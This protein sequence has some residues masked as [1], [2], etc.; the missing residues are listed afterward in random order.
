M[1]WGQFQIIKSPGQK[2]SGILYLHLQSWSPR[3]C[4]NIHLG[5]PHLFPCGKNIA[6][7]PFF[8][9]FKFNVLV[10]LKWCRVSGKEAGSRKDRW[11]TTICEVILII[12]IT[13]L[14]PPIMP[15]LLQCLLWKFLSPQTKEVLDQHQLC[16]V[17]QGQQN[18]LDSPR[19]GCSSRTGATWFYLN[20]ASWVV[21]VRQVNHI[22][23][24]NKGK[25]L[26]QH[27]TCTHTWGPECG[28]S[29]PTQKV[30]HDGTGPWSQHSGGGDR[31]IPRAH[32]LDC[33]AK[34][35][36]YRFSERSQPNIHTHIHTYV[37]KQIRW[38]MIKENI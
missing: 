18:I 12:I 38:R 36:S 3:S 17:V 25:W 10:N 26:S 21:G 24:R 19:P 7:D 8:F 28:V 9:F 34:S 27:S 6:S 4:S 23:L 2:S 1:L 22:G 14:N 32:W 13:V 20:P 31:S 29:V 11:I 33:L 16:Q 37:S 15:L 30:G 5:N 35:C